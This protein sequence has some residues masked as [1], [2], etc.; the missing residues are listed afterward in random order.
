MMRLAFGGPGKILALVAAVIFFV[1]SIGEWPSGL[2]DFEPVALGLAV[3]AVSFA[4][5]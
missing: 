5:K 2:D 4:L 1:A 3:L